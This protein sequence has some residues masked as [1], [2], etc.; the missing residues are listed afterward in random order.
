MCAKKSYVF[1]FR[2]NLNFYKKYCYNLYSC[3]IFVIIGNKHDIWLKQKNSKLN[4]IQINVWT[5]QMERS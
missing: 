3:F 1:E 2:L 5:E 4:R